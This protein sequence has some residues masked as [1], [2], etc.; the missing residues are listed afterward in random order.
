VAHVIDVDGQGCT[1]VRTGEK[2]VTVAADG[3]LVLIVVVPTL[4]VPATIDPDVKVMVI[5]IQRA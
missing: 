3:A 2:P 1:G 5:R 4:I